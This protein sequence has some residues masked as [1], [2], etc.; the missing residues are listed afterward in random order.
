MVA[1]LTRR[2][3]L[4][5][6]GRMTDDTQTPDAPAADAQAADAPAAE[7]YYVWMINVPNPQTGRIE[8]VPLVYMARPQPGTPHGKPPLCMGSVDVRTALT[9]ADRAQEAAN[10]LKTTVTLYHYGTCTLVT[11]IQQ[12][13]VQVAPANTLI[14]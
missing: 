7:S 1:C 13:M 11:Q 10:A 8:R 2:A 4:C 5:L 3:T 12:Q 9:M 6:I 14:Q